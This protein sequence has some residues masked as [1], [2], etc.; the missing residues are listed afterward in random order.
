MGTL[1]GAVWHYFKGLRNSPKLP[2][3]PF[4]RKFENEK[5]KKRKKK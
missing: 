1:G 2:D 4:S 5:E 3:D